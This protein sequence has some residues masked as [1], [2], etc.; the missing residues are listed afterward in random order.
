MAGG[1]VLDGVLT[2]LVPTAEED[3]DLL[4]RWFACPDF[5]EHWGAVPISRDEVAEKYV[6]RRRPRVE[7]FLVLAQ[8]TPVGYAQYWHADGT[9][10]GI[11]M[12]LAPDAR[13]R[14]LGPDAARALL[15]HVG[16]TLGWRRVTVDPE[17]GNVR[18]VR[19][20]EKAGFRQVSGE[21]EGLLMEFSFS[22][23]KGTPAPRPTSNEPYAAR[24][25]KA[26]RLTD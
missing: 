20:W 8:G 16:G 10:G 14:G 2:R 21:A 4:A 22:P 3:V 13:G 5:V 6:G 9:E 25:S 12:V 26:D 7:S 17:R 1:V 11:D 19:A 18:A 23:P 24:S 15:A